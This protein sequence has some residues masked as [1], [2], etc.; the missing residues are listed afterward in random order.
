MVKQQ[1]GFA[2]EKSDQWRQHVAAPG[3]C[4]LF[5]Q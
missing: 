4:Q 3:A 1:T 5:I 2:D